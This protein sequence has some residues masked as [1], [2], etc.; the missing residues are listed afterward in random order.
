MHFSDHSIP[1]ETKG[2]EPPL[3]YLLLAIFV[4]LVPWIG[5]SDFY[6][7][8]EPREAIAAQSML[9]TGDWILPRA[10]N[11]EIPSKP[12]LFHWL[13]AL[14]SLPGGE[15]TEFSAR[16]PSAL[17]AFAC[18][19]FFVAILKGFLSRF[20]V[21]LFAVILTFSFEWLRASASARVDMVHAGFLA[22]GLLAS[23][24]AISRSNSNWWLLSTCSFTLATLG[25]G[26]VALVIPGIVLCIWTYIHPGHKVKTLATVI[27]C[28]TCS[29]LLSLSWYAA[30]YARAPQEFY[31][32]IWEE[33]VARFTGT[34][35]EEAHNH[36]F[37][38]IL[39][40]LVLGTLPW[41]PFVIWILV[42]RRSG[43]E[44]IAEFWNQSPEIFRFSVVAA[45]A[46]VA[47]YC[48]PASKRS[49][50]LLASYP[51]LAILAAGLLRESVQ[52]ATLLRV[53]GV[54]C[55][56]IILAQSVI[57]PFAIAPRSSERTIAD[58]LISELNTT[59][60]IFSYGSE[61]YGAAFYTARRFLKLEEAKPQTAP[62]PG[63]LVLALHQDVEGL[64]TL[65]QQR[66]T[67]V[68]EIKE[69]T[70]GKKKASLF[71][72]V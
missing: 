24:L 35:I 28:L 67:K 40:S 1:Q 62:T 68:E 63:D 45:G 69:I 52:K 14:I 38:Y 37:L 61:F 65:L 2:W 17:I 18:L 33:N 41:S 4:S 48:F 54:G 42:K 66:Q 15:V 50:Y 20:E 13:I 3:L 9:S 71:R 72:V 55:T 21:A 59:S 26:P 10:Y 25:K 12:P 56:L 51:F 23:F 39:G 49:V 19:G 36:S 30:A 31:A 29:L 16:A 11:E 46:I 8:G 32:R 27:I 44:G 64:K 6:T 22:A 57:I 70:F 34:M 7:K 60:R 5:L 58:N 47:F 43:R 53:V